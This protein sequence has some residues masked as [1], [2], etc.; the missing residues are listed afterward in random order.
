MGL[1]TPAGPVM[2]AQCPSTD[3]GYCP[4]HY[5]PCYHEDPLAFRLRT[6]W[7]SKGYLKQ[8]VLRQLRASSDDAIIT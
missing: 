5:A 1:G 3:A 8:P 6:A 7:V 4:G 2:V